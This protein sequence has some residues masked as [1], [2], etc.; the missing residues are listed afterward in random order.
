MENRTRLC[1]PSG[2]IYLTG[3]LPDQPI[4][5]VAILGPLI[6]GHL[7]Q[8]GTITGPHTGLGREPTGVAVDASGKIYVA[9]GFNT[10]TIYAPG[11]SGDVSPIATISGPHTQLAGPFDVK[12]DTQGNIYALNSGS[13]TKYAAGATG[14]ATP[15]AT[16]AGPNTGLGGGELAID[17]KGRIFTT[18][19]NGL[20]WGYFAAGANGNVAPVQ[21]FKDPCEFCASTGIAVDGAGTVY[22]DAEFTDGTFVFRFP[23]ASDGTYSSSNVVIV[24]TTA[25]VP[26]L[27]TAHIAV[28]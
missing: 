2:K 28:H 23:M 27:S 20:D 24:N 19:I 11:A 13:I 12:L 18:S 25:V 17:T 1:D 3:S 8:I 26:W 6:N 9:A 14:D 10:I 16:I 4:G 7:S 5:G 21:T 15:I 22:T